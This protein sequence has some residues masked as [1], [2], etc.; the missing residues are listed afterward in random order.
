MAGQRPP[1]SDTSD[2][3]STCA[4]HESIG[5]LRRHVV[6]LAV[7]LLVGTLAGCDA[8]RVP[9]TG[10]RYGSGRAQVR[11][12][13]ADVD[14]IG[15]LELFQGA[16]VDTTEENPENRGARATFRSPAGWQ[17]SLARFG[18]DSTVPDGEVYLL[19]A[20][21]A[22]DEPVLLISPTDSECSSTS[23]VTTRERFSG[24]IS[25]HRTDGPAGDAPIEIEI[26]FDVL[27]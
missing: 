24:T 16:Y 2:P 14:P 8:F 18:P 20:S 21:S 6:L 23:L 25:C 9:T 4:S 19:D 15:D 22:G 11:V 12:L 26:V 3:D 10:E 7:L 13:A 5:A 1:T 17:L 27:R